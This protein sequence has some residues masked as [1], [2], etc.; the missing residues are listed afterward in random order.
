[1]VCKMKVLWKF[2]AQWLSTGASSWL[3]QSRHRRRA[4][5]LFQ[6]VFKV[7]LGLGGEES[8]SGSQLLS[9]HLGG[10]CLRETL[11]PGPTSPFF[12]SPASEGSGKVDL[13]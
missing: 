8:G 6:V 4:Y 1:M 10:V 3:S 12:P 5:K 13:F 2:Q 7:L 11:S 9:I